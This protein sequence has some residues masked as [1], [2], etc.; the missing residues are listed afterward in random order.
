MECA[1]F[2]DVFEEEVGAGAC[3]VSE[4]GICMQFCEDQSFGAEKKLATLVALGA[5]VG[6]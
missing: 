3:V 1:Y 5:T 2:L 6:E 4:V